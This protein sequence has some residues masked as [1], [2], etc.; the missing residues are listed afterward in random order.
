[1]S[2]P[3]YLKKNNLQP[4]YYA[5]VVDSAGAAVSLVGATIYVTMKDAATGIVK[6]NRLTTGI[7]ITNGAGGLFEYH[8]QSGDTSLPGTYNIEFE[9]NPQAGGVF[10]LPDDTTQAQV[11]ITPSLSN[12]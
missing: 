6:I 10:T 9:I 7:T 4:Y 2:N 3:L 8:W 1:M 5:A 12:V 11:I